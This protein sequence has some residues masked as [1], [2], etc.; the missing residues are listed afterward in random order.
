MTLLTTLPGTPPLYDL[1]A[2]QAILGAPDAWKPGILA[3]LGRIKSDLFMRKC[4]GFIC[5]RQP[6]TVRR[7]ERMVRAWRDGIGTYFAIRQCTPGWS[8]A[9]TMRCAKHERGAA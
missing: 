1:D 9:G 8:R 3:A 5:R 2:E 7:G 4:A 6:R